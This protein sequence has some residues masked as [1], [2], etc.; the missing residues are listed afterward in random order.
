MSSA[1]KYTFN[2]LL[3]LVSLLFFQSAVFF[4]SGSI[5]VSPALLEE[6]EKTTFLL[7][8]PLS[9]SLQGGFAK[10]ILNAILFLQSLFFFLKM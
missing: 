6:N 5:L 7:S 8:L 1:I 4:L 9:F 3:L 2:I 10:C